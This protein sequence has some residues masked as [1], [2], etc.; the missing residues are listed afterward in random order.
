MPRFRDV[1]LSFPW[2]RYDYSLLK[3]PP[4]LTNEFIYN[5]SLFIEMEPKI[6][7]KNTC[8]PKKL[9]S[10]NDIKCENHPSGLTGRKRD[11]PA[12]VA[13]MINFGFDADVLEIHLNELYPVVDKIFILEQRAAHFRSISKPLIWERV[14]YQPRFKKFEDKIVHLIMDDKEMTKSHDNSIWRNEGLQEQKRWDYFLDWNSKTNYFSDDDIIGFGDSDEIAS[15]HNINLLKNCEI[16]GPVDIGIW[17]THGA[18]NKKFR[19]DFPVKGHPF[20]LGDPTYYPIK[21]AKNTKPYPSR[22]RGKSGR[23]L[24]GGIHLSRYHYLPYA[25][26][27][28]I[29]A[30]ETDMKG[31]QKYTKEII[32]MLK[33]GSSPNEIQYYDKDKVLRL[34]SQRLDDVTPDS[35]G[36]DEI[37]LP[38]FLECNLQRYPSLLNDRIP[39]QRIL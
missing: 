28:T 32:N 11:Y 29:C 8:K 17:F 25:I 34:Y 38:W 26:I 23:F 31:I 35:Y 10:Y 9:E 13:H 36:K 21:D 33:K 2:E 27:K 4:S 19:S 15:M 20:T 30:S 7:I 14:R 12:K 24:L 37:I 5:M 3:A 6:P 18:I 22:K 1:F 39:D 16:A